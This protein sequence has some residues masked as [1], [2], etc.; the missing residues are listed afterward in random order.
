MMFTHSL[1]AS[2]LVSAVHHLAYNIIHTSTLWI[3]ND[4]L[5]FHLSIYFLHPDSLKCH[6]TSSIMQYLA[7]TCSS[8]VLCLPLRSTFL[9]PLKYTPSV[10]AQLGPSPMPRADKDRLSQAL[11]S[12]RTDLKSP[13]VGPPKE[14]HVTKSQINPPTHAHHALL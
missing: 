2:A 1:Q 6:I 13:D 7:I 14:S 9:F 8:S 10:C 3:I 12:P 4:K 5:I 11:L